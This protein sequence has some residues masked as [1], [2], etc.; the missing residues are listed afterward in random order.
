MPIIMEEPI[1]I[2]KRLFI[3]V[4][5]PVKVHYGKYYTSITVAFTGLL[6]VCFLLK[7]VLL[8]E[9]VC[10]SHSCTVTSGVA[11][12]GHTRAR[13]RA[14]FLWLASKLLITINQAK[15]VA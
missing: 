10:I 13:A 12:H 1:F 4:K 5:A 6:Y 8:C 7:H 2:A 9:H 11:K 3:L 15:P 14:T